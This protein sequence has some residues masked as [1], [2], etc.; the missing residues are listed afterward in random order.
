MIRE[1]LETANRWVAAHP[2]T[3]GIVLGAVLGLFL[4]LLGLMKD[5]PFS[6]PVFILWAVIFPTV[7]ALAVYIK[8]N[9]P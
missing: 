9:Q 4:V 8:R 3:Y 2:V 5:Q 7:M 1:R 6:W